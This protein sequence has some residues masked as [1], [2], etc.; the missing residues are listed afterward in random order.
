MIK[1]DTTISIVKFEIQ[2]I[3]RFLLSYHLLKFQRLGDMIS[4]NKNFTRWA[5]YLRNGHILKD[6]TVVCT[7]SSHSLLFHVILFHFLSYSLCVLCEQLNNPTKCVYIVSVLLNI[8]Y[9]EMSDLLFFLSEICLICT[10]VIKCIMFL[11]R[12]DLE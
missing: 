12:V 1:K 2:S 5:F 9:R 6:L 8:I 3:S 11:V 10:K 7:F 4:L